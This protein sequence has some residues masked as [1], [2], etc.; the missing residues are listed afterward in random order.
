MEEQ[1]LVLL[2]KHNWDRYTVGNVVEFCLFWTT[3]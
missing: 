2:T 3:L 1:S